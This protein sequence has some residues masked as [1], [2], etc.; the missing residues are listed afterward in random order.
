MPT[1]RA[2]SPTAGGAGA[3][4]NMAGV[5]KIEIRESEVSLK[6]LLDR[7]KNWFRERKTT[8]IVLTENEKI[9][10]CDSCGLS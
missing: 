1:L 6:Q 10:Q 8:S 3:R 4:K 5:C 2:A 9:S 7:V